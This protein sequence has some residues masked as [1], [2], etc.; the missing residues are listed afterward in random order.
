MERSVTVPGVQAKL[1]MSLVKETQENSGARLTVVGA[2]G[3]N[4]ILKPPSVLF[5]EMPANEHVTMRIAEVFGIRAVPSGLIRLKSGELS[6][7]SRRIDRTETTTCIS[8]TSP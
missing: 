8:R 4:Y 2:P 3:G 1:S 5:H 6:Y 7:L